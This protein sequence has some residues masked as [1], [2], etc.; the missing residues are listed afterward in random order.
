MLL[1]LLTLLTPG[2]HTKKI[3]KKK[4]GCV[5]LPGGEL[6]ELQ[7][8]NRVMECASGPL[9]DSWRCVIVL[10]KELVLRQSW[11][12][13]TQISLLLFP[14]WGCEISCFL[15]VHFLLFILE[16][17]SLLLLHLYLFSVR[18]RLSCILMLPFISHYYIIYLVLL[19]T[20]CFSRKRSLTLSS[21]K[22][23]IV[24]N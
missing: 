18:F 4:G 7:S 19:I 8:D 17:T 6:M 5:S 3:R 14:F 13:A 2:T 16:K 1:S 21:W 15:L 24:R 12:K 11:W 10:L 9:L 20:V 23:N 22:L